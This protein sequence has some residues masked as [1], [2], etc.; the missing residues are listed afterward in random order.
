MLYH[1][2][3]PTLN[4]WVKNPDQIY[5]KVFQ[6]RLLESYRCRYEIRIAL[7]SAFR[8]LEQMYLTNFTRSNP[9]NNLRFKC[10][11]FRFWI[12]SLFTLNYLSFNI[13]YL[14]VWLKLLIDQWWK[15][16]ILVSFI[17]IESV[18]NLDLIRHTFT[19]KA[20]NVFNC[21]LKLPKIR[22]RLC[23]KAS[24]INGGILRLIAS[25]FTVRREAVFTF[26]CG[27]VN[28]IKR[29]SRLYSER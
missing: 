14:D 21:Q 24:P 2:T 23:W 6:L 10:K 4:T 29:R 11:K 8:I 26:I 19:N 7:T 5:G 3:T 18:L 15:C 16:W 28:A 12:F 22:W 1:W 13:L 17:Y 9:W 20:F 27:L 25:R